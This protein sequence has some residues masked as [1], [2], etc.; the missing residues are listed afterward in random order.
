MNDRERKKEYDKKWYQE[1]REFILGRQ[2]DYYQRT[3]ECRR[4]AGKKYYQNNRE[5]IIKVSAQWKIDNK[6]RYKEIMKKHFNTE[7]GYFRQLWETTKKSGKPN[8]FKDFDDFYNHW[9]EQKKIR[10]MKCPGT[11]V[12]MTTKASFN[13]EGEFKRCQTNVS[14]DRILSS[15][16]YSHQNL[17]FTCWNY[18]SAKCNITPKMA[19]AFLKIVKERYGTDEME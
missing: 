14:K 18:N 9:L 2:R 15:R 11:G 17:I 13:K 12:E 19:K 4:E 16:G 3:R 7:R 1:N 5:K 8:S 10:G 6:E